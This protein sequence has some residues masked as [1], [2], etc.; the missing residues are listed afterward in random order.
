MEY[1]DLTVDMEEFY[2]WW[3]GWRPDSNE[4]TP[5]AVSFE[6]WMDFKIFEEH[7]PQPLLGKTLWYSVDQEDGWLET[8]VYFSGVYIRKGV[9][10]KETD[11][12]F[13]IEGYAHPIDKYQFGN[14]VF[15]SKDYLLYNL[16]YDGDHLY[17]FNKYNEAFKSDTFILEE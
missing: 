2:K 17:E 10:I 7:Q 8:D 16:H 11:A 12:E 4:E 3:Q 1:L 13:F 14:Q 15:I 9:V 5:N 6:I